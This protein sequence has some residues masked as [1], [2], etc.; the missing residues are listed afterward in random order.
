MYSRQGKAT[1]P[2][3]PSAFLAL[4]QDNRYIIWRQV[5]PHQAHRLHVYAGARKG[6]GPENRN[7]SQM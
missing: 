6:D 4:G 2:Y 3:L 1:S 7:K 5:F